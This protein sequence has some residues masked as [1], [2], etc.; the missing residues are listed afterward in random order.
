MNTPRIRGW[1]ASAAA[2]TLLSI[3]VAATIAHLAAG[4]PSGAGGDRRRCG[5]VRS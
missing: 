4:D 1:R 2:C 5:I 3:G